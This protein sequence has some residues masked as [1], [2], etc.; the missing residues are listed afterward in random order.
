[1]KFTRSGEG[2]SSIDRREATQIDHYDGFGGP[3]AVGTEAGK[4][5]L[6]GS[7]SRGQLNES[8]LSPV[9]GRAG[10]ALGAFQFDPETEGAKQIPQADDPHE[11]ITLRHEEAA[12]AA[13][14]DPVQRLDRV[15]LGR[16]SIALR[17]VRMSLPTVC[18]PHSPRGTRDR[19]RVPI[20]PCRRPSETTGNVLRW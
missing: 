14:L 16:V 20:Q 3:V 10:P 1:M 11:A 13:S 12:G 19:A 15:R 4:G 9:S 18:R 6:S 7:Y 2:P 17:S 8:R 5:L